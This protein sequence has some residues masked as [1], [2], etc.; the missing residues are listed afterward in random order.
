M[1]SPLNLKRQDAPCD[2]WV[3]ADLHEP[4][5]RQGLHGS[6]EFLSAAQVEEKERGAA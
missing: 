4:L 5:V 3:W 6:G 1:P 2:F